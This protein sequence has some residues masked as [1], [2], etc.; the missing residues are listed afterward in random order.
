MTQQV[1][2]PEA[3]ELVTLDGSAGAV[4]VDLDAGPGTPSVRV[5]KPLSGV[6]FV[7]LR[8]VHGAIRGDIDAAIA[9][10][11]DRGDFILGQAVEEFEAA[12]AAYCGAAYAV[13]VDSGFSGLELM[14]R[15]LG[16]G[17][18]DEVITAANTFV[19]TVGAIEAAGARPILVDIDPATFNLD[20]A[21][22]GAAV[23]PATAAILPVHLY[24]QPADMDP[25][26]EVARRHGLAV[27]ED[28][29]QAHGARYN[30]ARTGSLGHAAAFSFYPAKNLGALG[31]GGMVTTSDP[32]VAERL[33][34]LR[35]LGTTR[36]YHHDV[37]GFNHRL[38]TLH[39]AVLRVKLASLDEANESRR[40]AASLYRD[41]LP[42]GVM[43]PIEAPWAEHVYHLYVTRIGDRDDAIRYLA[44]RNISAMIHYP[45]PVHL[46]PA[47]ADLGYGL[48]DFPVAEEIAGQI[49]SLPMYPGIPVVAVA[50]V[51]EAIEGFLRG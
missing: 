33:R 47:Y 13:G 20:A 16:I 31:D 11:L 23:T 2:N 12:F 50:Q 34:L 32:E 35:N 10:V 48:G 24:G 17:A 1:G 4:L 39:A 7:D 27:L 41:L 44:E 30:G 5:T 40:R 49:L 8:S 22:V 29:A 38:D 42:A 25:I 26:N 37:R 3:T 9:G 43:A 15:A 36:K 18:G 6:P 14:I 28:A 51:V 21:Q 19:A 45:I 46:Q